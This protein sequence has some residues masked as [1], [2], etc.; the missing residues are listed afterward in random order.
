MSDIFLT[1]D[2]HFAHAA[3]FLWRPRGFNSADEMNEAI[4]EKWNSVVKPDDIVFHLGDI[5]LTDTAKGLECFKRL[6]GQIS[7]VWGNHDSPARQE[8]IEKMPII[9]LGY[10]HQ[11]KIGK[12]TFYLSHYPTLTAN[13]NC[14]K[15][16]RQNVINFHAHTHQKTNF[17]NPT[18][19]FMYHVG[20]DSHNCTPVHI[21][22]A[23][24]DIRQRWE[25]I[26]HLP[27]SAIPE[28]NYPYD[29]IFT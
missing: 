26:G 6:N 9:T 13:Y 5:T 14:N 12:W 8:L 29:K 24:S 19:P 18:N 11:L 20:M 21:D 28:D 1:S 17:L 22:E 27:S 3:E 16:F 23:I 15:H 7:V 25:E 4:I 10:A 2:T